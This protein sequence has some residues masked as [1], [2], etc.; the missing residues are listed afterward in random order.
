MEVYADVRVVAAVFI[1]VC[2]RTLYVVLT[3]LSHE[4]SFS[5]ARLIPTCASG[6]SLSPIFLSLLAH[7]DYGISLSGQRT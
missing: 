2:I 5:I 4:C 3:I 1:S 6:R 7:A